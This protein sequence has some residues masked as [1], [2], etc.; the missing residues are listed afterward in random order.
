MRSPIVRPTSRTERS[1]L[2]THGDGG[3]GGEGRHS[4]TQATKTESDGKQ[5]KK[6][7]EKEIE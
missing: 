2:P 6:L 7:K 5:G 3:G 1:E 4:I